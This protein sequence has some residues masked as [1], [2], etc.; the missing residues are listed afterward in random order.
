[1][2]FEWDE[3]KEKINMQKHGISFEQAS[4]AFADPFALNKYDGEHSNEEDRWI[5]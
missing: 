5:L 2:K 4:Y 3:K 1:M